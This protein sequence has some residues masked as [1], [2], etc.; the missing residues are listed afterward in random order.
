MGSSDFFHFIV[1]ISIIGDPSMKQKVDFKILIIEFAEPG[2][3]CFSFAMN[4]QK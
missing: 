3:I 2:Y 1:E 4:F